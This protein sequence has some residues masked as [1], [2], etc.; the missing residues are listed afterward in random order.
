MAQNEDVH[1]RCMA[2]KD[3]LYMWNEV[4]KKLHHRLPI[5]ASKTTKTKYA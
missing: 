1:G 5:K 4:G 2:W 3:R